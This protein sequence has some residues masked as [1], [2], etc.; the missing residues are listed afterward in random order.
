MKVAIN[1]GHCP[2]LDSGAVGEYSTEADIVKYVAE[3]VVEDLQK[4][5]IEALFIQEN[6]LE[7]I[8]RIANNF[9][10][11][12]FVSIHCNSAKSHQAHGTET[13][14]FDGSEAGYKIANCVQKQLIS[15]MQLTDRGTKAS[16]KL[17]VL[18][19]T[20]MPACLAEL[21]FISNQAEEKY[22]NDH[23]KIMG[24]AIARAITDY[25]NMI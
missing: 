15:T 12:L 22:L 14:Y 25:A 17:Y 21:A 18:R 11:D 8:C 9:G 23:K 7:N 19:Y 5:G 13:Y 2:G 1:A 4:I 3:V 10:A 16:Q 20:N 6:E 24:D